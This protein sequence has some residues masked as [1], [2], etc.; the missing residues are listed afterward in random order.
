MTE[1]NKE[2]RQWVVQDSPTGRLALKFN[3]RVLYLPMHK[4]YM[5]THIG[6][7]RRC[8]YLDG[9]YSGHR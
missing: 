2:G 6:D 3:E 1:K 4:R 9:S 5:S 8:L 7:V